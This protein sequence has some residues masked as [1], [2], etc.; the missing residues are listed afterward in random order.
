MTPIALCGNTICRSLGRR[1]VCA[2]DRSA[3]TIPS[4]AA[5]PPLPALA[6][7]S[8]A[9]L[10][11]FTFVL[12]VRLWPEWRHNPDLS[13]G[14]FMPFLFL[15]M[16]HESRVAGTPRYLPSGPLLRVIFGALVLLGL[17]ALALVGLY[18]AALGWS[19]TLVEFL[20]VGALVLLL[21]AG[22]VVFADTRVRALPCNWNSAVAI[23]LWLLSAPIPPGTYTRLTLGL[24]LWVSKSVLFSLHVLG[25]AA[26]R[27]GNIIEL[28]NGSVG[29]EEAC[30]GVR[31]LVSCVFAGFFF[32]ATLVR[33]PWARA[34]IIGLAGPLALGMNFVRS[35]TLTLLA[36]SGVNIA[37]AWH[38]VTGYAVLALTA[39]ILGALALRL[40]RRGTPSPLLVAPKPGEDGSPLNAQLSFLP[41]ASALLLTLALG[42]LFVLNTRPS[43][44]NA[45]PVPDLLAVLPAESPGW[46]VDT[47]R[48]LYQFTDVLQTQYLAQRTYTGR[49]ATGTPV[50][51]TLYLAYWPAGHSTV[52]RVAAHTPDACWPG[53]GWVPQPVPVTRENPIVAGRTLASAEY[54]FFKNQNFPQHVWFWHLF[55]GR[56]L[57]YQNPYSTREL[58]D[59]AWRYGFRHDGDQLFVRVSSTGP[60][61]DIAGEPLLRE[62]FAHLQPLGL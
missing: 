18:A 12:S 59:L 35:L 1:P 44:R 11:G 8:L 5:R 29:V 49:T 25:I 50:Q 17:L 38:D 15:F 22:L 30:S 26:H 52:S 3:M 2:C 19:H 24:Q 31:S 14:L 33:R 39:L 45:T 56:P 9:L 32:S 21:G 13:H 23:G 47:S 61:T 27:T 7:L 58:F 34:L 42:T 48:D 57:A 4:A 43:P 60:W 46:I 51:I 54:R 40:E 10:A 41:L 55:D 37:G 16:L 20:L 28:A 36:N 53:S 6:K 62:F